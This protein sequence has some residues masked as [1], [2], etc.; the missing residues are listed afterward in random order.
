[1]GHFIGKNNS[2]LQKKYMIS[3]KSI[4]ILRGPFF[5]KIVFL[6]PYSPSF[7]VPH[8]VAETLNAGL[9]TGNLALLS[10]NHLFNVFL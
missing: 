6:K 9:L 3:F 5:P 8:F 1:M 10:V 4:K 7:A 2:F